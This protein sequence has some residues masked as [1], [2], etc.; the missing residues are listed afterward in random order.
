[1][2]YDNI[3]SNE[4]IEKNI[5]AAVDG[6]VY[7]SNSLDY[8]IRLFKN[9]RN[10]IIH[11][12]SVVSAGSSDQNWMLD[13]DPLRGDTPAVELRKA[14]ASRYLKDAQGRLLRNGFLEDQ[15]SYCVQSSSSSLATTIH[16]FANKGMYDGLLV[17]RRGIGKVGEMFMGS[18]SAD[19]I[20]KCHEV[21]L[22]IIDGDVT[23]TRFLLAVQATPR[24][25]MAADH[26]GFVMQ[27]NPN[28]EICLY[29]SSSFFGSRPPVPAEEF[30]RQWGEEWCNEHLDLDDYLYQAHAKILVDS[31]ISEKQI[32]VIPP[33]KD[34]DAS[35]DLLRQ[36]KKHGCGTVV[37]GRRARD[38]EKG[39]LGG[40]SDRTTQHA[41]D[42]AVWLVG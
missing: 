34:L 14:K 11:L 17:G 36:A 33:H 16:H 21:P 39:L 31:G 15:I 23:S 37:I 28:T 20:S 13:V 42:T 5:L 29:H 40:V 38:V 19:L 10:L 4:I 7:S 41:Q 18:V 2:E 22:W 24:S 3:M 8:L 9:D 6:S 32:S 25:L 35:H 30:H 12:V 27:S 1:M 26:L